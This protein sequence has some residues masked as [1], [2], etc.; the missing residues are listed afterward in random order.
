M[1]TFLTGCVFE[2]ALR[3]LCETH[4]IDLG[5]HPTIDDMLTRLSRLLKLNK[6]ML[7]QLRAHKDLRNAAAHGRFNE[8]SEDAVK[9]MITDVRNFVANHLSIVMP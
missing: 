6:P 1:A 5:E 4:N 3:K 7:S 9:R 2:N 8:I